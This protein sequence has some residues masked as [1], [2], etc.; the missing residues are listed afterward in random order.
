MP[1]TTIN[2]AIAAVVA[3]HQS[4]LATKLVFMLGAGVLGAA[5]MAA[6][7]PPATRKELFKQAASA[8][9]GSMLFGAPAV[10]IVNHFVPLMDLAHATP[11][12][13]F[14]WAVPIYFTVGALSWGV[15][16][17]L[18]KVRGL[19]RDYGATVVAGSFSA[20]F[21]APAPAQ[22]PPVPIVPQSPKD[23]A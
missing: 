21:L 1:E 15:F 4:G 13:Y 8:G 14:E 11:Q 16:A 10:N 18:A 2:P 7:D 19:V 23:P 9:V 22:T 6:F 5:I 20:R 17:A 12:V 3:M